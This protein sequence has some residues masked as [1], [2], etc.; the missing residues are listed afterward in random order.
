MSF[1]KNIK[2]KNLF[3]TKYVCFIGCIAILCSLTL[4]GCGKREK[5]EDE[6]LYGNHFYLK[7][8][9]KKSTE[10]ASDEAVKKCVKDH[11]K[12][13]NVEL[14]DTFV[15]INGN[16]YQYRSVDRDLTFFV[17]SLLEGYGGIP[18]GG[19]TKQRQLVVVNYAQGIQNYY[20][21]Q[22]GDTLEKHQVNY[23]GKDNSD[24]IQ[25]YLNSYLE[26][27]KISKAVCEVDDIYK[28]ET[29]YNTIQFMKQYPLCDFIFYYKNADKEEGYVTSLEIDG[30]WSEES[31]YQYLSSEYARAN[32]NGTIADETIPKDV[33]D[34]AHKDILYNIYIDETNISDEAYYARYTYKNAKRMHGPMTDSFYSCP[35]YDALDSYLILLD[36]G[37]VYSGNEWDLMMDAYLEKL[38]DAPSSYRDKAGSE[39]TWNFAGDAYRIS[40]KNIGD[41]NYGDYEFVLY[42]NGVAQEIEIV[43]RSDYGNMTLGCVGI[44]VEDFANLFSLT[45]E[46]DEKTEDGCIIFHRK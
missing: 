37:P 6:E 7:V 42:K 25:I 28:N 44:K 19:T 5:T 17:E 16:K 39:I 3:I 31:L 1:I 15:A 30:S 32:A 2:N 11:V 8:V 45:Y 34:S 24:K 33:T 13:E 18:T 27:K 41:D 40:T 26:L 29:N 21:E 9:S 36:V 14:V 20:W 46:I 12:K 38:A 23:L 35:Y 4:I 10:Y 22:I 43:K